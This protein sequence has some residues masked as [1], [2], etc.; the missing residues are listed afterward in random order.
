MNDKQEKR[1]LY[2][3]GQ[4]VPVSEQVYKTYWGYTEKERYFMGKPKQE[5]FVYDPEEQI[6]TLLPSRED[7]YERLLETDQQFA[8]D[9]SPV[10]EQAVSSIWLDGLMRDLSEEEREIIRQLYF[11]DKSEREACAALHLART[12]FQRRKMALLEKLRI[13]LNETF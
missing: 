9:D 13:L 4:K 1:Y 10:E 11:L 2:I 7:S 3:D 12:T 6:A 8:A 5:T